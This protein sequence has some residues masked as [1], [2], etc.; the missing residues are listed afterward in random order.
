MQPAA[1]SCRF[2]SHRPSD[3]G[4]LARGRTG[5]RAPSLLAVQT[6]LALHQPREPDELSEVSRTSHRRRRL[7]AACDED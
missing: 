3:Q 6:K 4:T 2:L 7:H 1:S 5:M